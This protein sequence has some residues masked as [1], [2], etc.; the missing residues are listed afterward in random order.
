MPSTA[1]GETINPTLAG[2][3]FAVQRARKSLL[4]PF[5]FEIPCRAGLGVVGEPYVAK[6]SLGNR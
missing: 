1:F 6:V 5:R 2:G 4:A 3:G